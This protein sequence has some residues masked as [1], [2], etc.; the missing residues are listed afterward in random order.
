MRAMIWVVA[1]TAALVALIG[2]FCGAYSSNTSQA[3]RSRV[4]E[5]NAVVLS[6]N[7]EAA[8]A[9][10]LRLEEAW[11]EK[12]ALLCLWVNHQDIDD[13]SVGI[14]QLKVSIEVGETH[15]AL[16]YLAELDEALAHI[17]HRD[18]FKLRNIL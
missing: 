9:Q 16:R 14:Q 18:A 1:V 15:D 12:S 2:G 7:A 11:Q 5:M 3:L 4:M 8:M 13:V 17:Y 6:G 10:A